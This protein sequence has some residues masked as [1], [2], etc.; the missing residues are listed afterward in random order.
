[1]E[2]L[3]RRAP[4]RLRARY[5][6]AAALCGLCVLLLWSGGQPGPGRGL[7]PGPGAS[8][9]RE[10]APGDGSDSPAAGGD[11]GGGDDDGEAACPVFNLS[12]A[13]SGAED[14]A[15]VNAYNQ[16]TGSAETESAD[17][18][19][20]MW[21]SS[22][23]GDDGCDAGDGHFVQLFSLGKRNVREEA[24]TA[25]L[26]GVAKDC[27]EAQAG[28]GDDEDVNNATCV[29]RDG[30]LYSGPGLGGDSYINM[31]YCRLGHGVLGTLYLIFI[32]VLMF[33]MLGS[34]SEDFFCPALASLSGLLRLEPR[35]AGVTLLALG[36]GAPDVFSIIAS[37][38]AKSAAMAVGEVTGAG[39]FV[40]TAVV[41]AVAL[42]TDDGLKA[43]GMFLRDVCML[44]VATAL[45]LW[46]FVDG[47]VEK[48]EAIAFLVLYVGYVA[49]V[50]IGDRVPPMLKKERPHWREERARKAAERRGE[51]YEPAAAAAAA[52]SEGGAEGDQPLLDQMSLEAA[53]APEGGSR[54]RED[55]EDFF[56]PKLGSINMANTRFSYLSVT[57]KGALLSADGAGAR[58][59]APDT[60]PLRDQ[61]STK[62]M[63]GRDIMSP[64]MTGAGFSPRT[65]PT[66]S[67]S[68]RH[69]KGASGHFKTRHSI[70]TGSMDVVQAGRNTA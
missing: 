30:C 39:N 68:I 18:A 34:T 64:D 60:S 58:A 66:R 21:I 50:M 46:V 1:M 13:W 54:N 33:L 17:T 8:A 42:T 41:G 31:Y 15:L 53:G 61:W 12:V 38:K 5:R 37:V 36:N 9:R 44:V 20:C 59:A 23:Q 7:A 4:W 65:R 32:L 11:D 24:C 14:V 22:H 62:S 40:T 56:L 63:S 48:W 2:L 57:P 47:E 51:A 27:T 43:R 6:A 70:R 25:G 28:F 29:A 35:V 16:L 19:Q 10:L 3:Q 69:K 45:L 67:S 26:H 55:D 52:A 49:I